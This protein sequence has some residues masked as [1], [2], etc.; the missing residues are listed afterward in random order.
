M[1]RVVHPVVWRRTLREPSLFTHNDMFICLIL[2]LF[3]TF[4]SAIY[5]AGTAIKKA[6]ISSGLIF[7]ILMTD[8][9]K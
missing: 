5:G 6:R 9:W 3:I 7:A 8:Y 1:V 2:P 4:E